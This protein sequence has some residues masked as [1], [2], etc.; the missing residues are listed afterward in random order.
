MLV[1]TKLSREQRDFVET[2]HASAR[3]LLSLIEEVLDISKIEAGK[4]VIERTDFDLHLLVNST[5][6]MLRA[7][8]SQ[9]GL[10]LNVYVAPE[11]PFMLSGDPLHLRQILINLVGNAIKFTERGGIEIRVAKQSRSDP[12][13]LHFEVIDSGVGIPLAVQEKIFESF[14]QADGSTTRRFGGTLTQ[15]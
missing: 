1:D 14:T 9:K 3:T 10:Y 15:V 8:A 6:K 7:Q 2:I 5:A 11:V 12:P 4:I 13:V